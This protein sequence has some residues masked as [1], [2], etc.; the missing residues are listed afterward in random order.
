MAGNKIGTLT[1]DVVGDIGG[2]QSSMR[3]AEKSVNS[4]AKRMTLS[5]Q[6]GLTNASSLIRGFAGPLAAALSV[7]QV[8]QYA[9]AW[10]ELNNRL[11]L[12]T[13]TNKDLATASR[14]IYTIAQQTGQALGSTSEVYSRIAKN[15]GTYSLSLQQ[16]ADI[17]NTVS[18]AV[19][20]SGTSAESASSGLMQFGQAL[21]AQN[22]QGAELNSILEQVPGLALA[23]A[24]GLEVPVGALKEMGKQGALT[25]AAVV[26]ALE[27]SKEFVDSQFGNITLTAVQQ[28]ERM[29]NAMMRYVGVLDEALG[30]SRAFGGVMQTVTGYIEDQTTK[31]D[32]LVAD[33]DFL[34]EKFG[35]IVDPIGQAFNSITGFLENLGIKT[36]AVSSVM[37]RSLADVFVQT[38]ADAQGFLNLMLG[39]FTG[40]DGITQNVVYNVQ[41]A[42]ENGFTYI[43]ARAVEQINKIIRALNE[44]G[45]VEIFGQKMGVNI[46]ELDPVV[47]VY[48]EFSNVLTDFKRGFDIGSSY[49]TFAD[50]LKVQRQL[51]KA[52]DESIGLA[53]E[54]Y[55][56]DTPARDIDT[57][58]PGGAAGGG[59]KKGKGKKA[60]KSDLEK[61]LEREQKQM[62]DW[63]KRQRER[64]ALMGTET[65]L[66]KL[67]A[68][69]QLGNWSTISKANQERMK[70]LAAEV[71]LAE[72][73]NDVLEAYKDLTGVNLAKEQGIQIEA[74]NMAYQNGKMSLDAYNAAMLQLQA[75]ASNQRLE[76]GIGTSADFINVTVNQMLDGFKSLQSES[77]E[78]FGN[79]GSD[80]TSGVADS[81]GNAIVNAEN[82]GEALKDVA[83][84]AIGDLISGL[85]KL[86]IQYAILQAIGGGASQNATTE[87]VANAATIAAAWAPA[88]AAVS[89]AS[90]GSNGIPAAAAVSG[91]NLLSIGFAQAGGKG[92]SEGGFTGVGG[93]YQPM[94]VVHGGEYV[95]SAERTRQIG[96]GTLERLHAGYADGGFV[97]NTSGAVASVNSGAGTGD[98][99]IVNQTSAKIGSVE[100]STNDEGQRIIIIRETLDAVANQLD[101]PNSKIS[102]KFKNNYQAKRR[103]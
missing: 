100:Q 88:A 41:A 67:N 72:R 20:I 8:A 66:E 35:D 59:G 76:Q 30:G 50:D 24:K 39:V 101:N 96:L 21:A 6:S 87:S 4:T 75:T 70:Q 58:V 90:F 47:E 25:G 26:A 43:A 5:L 40:L 22:L 53:E 91:V 89:L 23:I 69:L 79:I 36:D 31:I 64:I 61:Q 81:I 17:T 2:L 15:A 7:R 29:N 98:I 54:Y 18:K 62:L 14:D 34:A 93:K 92:F 60:G 49:F 73:R 56:S 94:G 3:R 55:K 74:L 80:L 102:R 42:F 28:Q 85:I 97:G 10:T 33:I 82:L 1:I 52:L 13:A 12:V 11:K 37:N 32:D 103:V 86:G 71:D 57:G 46:K 99:Q 44:L 78:L 51:N 48:K 68:E 38:A 95:F 45:S 77:A 16:V 63:I 65:E 19:A 9:Q 27:K 83:K 84:N